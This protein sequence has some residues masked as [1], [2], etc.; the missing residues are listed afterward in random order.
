MFIR[1]S[2]T[3]ITRV[4]AIVGAL[5]TAMTVTLL[6]PPS[7]RRRQN[8]SAIVKAPSRGA[9]TGGPDRKFPRLHSP[10]GSAASP[11][12]LVNRHL[13]FPII[14]LIAALALA[15]LFLMPGGPL[16]AQ[17]DGTIPYPENGMDAVAT[18]TG[19]DPEERM[20][21]WSL[22]DEAVSAA[23][24][25]SDD[26]ADQEHFMISADGV[27]SF[28]FSP[29]YEMPRGS[30]SDNDNTNTY[31]V[32]V[33]ASDDALGAGTTDNPVQMAYKK[34]T[35][36]VTDVDEDGTVTLS[37]QQPQESRE[38][39]ATLTDDDATAAQV[40]AAK[41]KWEHSSAAD[42]PW[43]P[44]LTAT[45]SA[46]P[47]LGV[48][49]KYLR[50]TATYTDRHGPGKT[51]QA[52]SAN[53]VRAAPAN[54]AAPV[55]PDEDSIDSGI[56]V[57]R[58]VNENSPPGTKVGKPVIANDASGDT[59]TYTLTTNP[60]DRFDIG[61]ASG[62][63][64][65]GARTTLNREDTTLTDFT[66]TVTVTA[67]DPAGGTA[68]QEVTITINDVNEAPKMTEGAT[69]VSLAENTA[70]TTMVGSYEA[71]DPESTVSGN[72]CDMDN[73][74]WSVSGMDAGDFDISNADATFGQ[75]T[76]KKVPN[77][78]KPADSNGDNV[79][80]VTVVV[81]DKDAKK[82]LTAMR[83]VTI[84]VTNAEE[85][86]TVTLS[87]EQP[88]VGIELT[89]TL[90]DPDG[91]VADSVKWTW[92]SS[93]DGTGTAIPMADSDTY[94]PKET[95]PLSAKASYTD[96]HGAVKSAVGTE[97]NVVEN[98]ANV[99]PKFP[100]TETGVREVAE[101]NNV[102]A[103][104]RV[105]ADNPS[106]TNDPVNATDTAGE[107]LTYTLSG[108]DSASFDIDRGTGQL[109]TKAALDYET[110]KSYMVT[111]TATD[112][113]GLSASIDVTITVTNV[114]EAPDIAGEDIAEDFREN[115]SNLEIER[116]RA[117]DPEE[118]MVYWSLAD[119][120]VSAAE[121]TSDDVADQEHFMI[122]ADGVLSFKFSP[123][124]EMPRGSVSDNT[125]TNT[126]K[127]VVV[128]SDDALGAGT[129][130]NPVQMAYKKVTVMVTDV[131]ED[132]TVTLSAER[133]QV[134]VVLTATYNDLDNEK[135]ATT[136]LTWKWYLGGLPIPN[137][138]TGDT[139]P[140]STYTPDKSGLSAGRGQLHQDRW[141]CKKSVE[142]GHCPGGAC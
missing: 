95:G 78:E 46:Y 61:Q 59:L 134:G 60:E 121:V 57:G 135:P 27:L 1:L 44:I 18:F 16:H 103:N 107:T 4:V 68:P 75:L 122:S 140:T 133:A 120:A 66:Y 113:D 15:L 32:V 90:M 34:V 116:F 54:N 41:W 86:G 106:T 47:P 22:A 29:D 108:T 14:A 56:Q 10:L 48:V 67:T 139:G 93:A 17:D 115:G 37:A 6:S 98:T 73:C 38:L 97:A 100:D 12:L 42:G 85:P 129:T 101:N 81:T 87:T 72:D 65:V 77:Y 49:D 30:V 141:Q 114:D 40:T 23:E 58:K 110:K 69:R 123:D 63:I 71:T 74:T 131:D 62:Q 96:G 5:L 89:S 7:F 39:T 35:V 33:V 126:Y 112:P 84:T 21:Y 13:A 128:A 118:R 124:Y 94:T 76:F 136:T 132:E 3:V 8:A 104:V 125:N 31:K 9:L 43:T 50:V 25:T 26:V 102:D 24:V 19:T 105:D 119:E 55:F 138:G 142:D 36:M 53:M 11:S 111:V 99:A 20:V 137:A 2:N 64:T 70:I 79:Y 117:T 52:V 91:V 80:M 45:T 92:H 83:D 51:E 109:K 28:K 88:K 130:D 82:K 127:V